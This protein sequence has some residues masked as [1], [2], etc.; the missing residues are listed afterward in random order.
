MVELERDF[1]LERTKESL[2]ARIAKWI[3][4]GNPKG[5]LQGSMRDKDKEKI[6][7][8]LIGMCVY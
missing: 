3:K 5:T 1:V 6:L 4:R 7:L 8:V 2:G